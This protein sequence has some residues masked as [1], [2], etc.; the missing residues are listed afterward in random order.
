[1]EDGLVGSF[2]HTKLYRDSY[3]NAVSGGT[4]LTRLTTQNK[5]EPIPVRTKVSENSFFPYCIKEWS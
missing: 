1:M 3:L 4:Y 5:I 2:Y